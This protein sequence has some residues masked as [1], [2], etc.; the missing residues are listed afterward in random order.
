MNPFDATP[1]SLS[2][3]EGLGFLKKAKKAVKKVV[4]KVDKNLPGA[5][6]I[7]K[8]LERSKKKVVN[9]VKRSPVAQA[10]VLAAGA[11]V[12]GPAVGAIAGKFGMAAGGAK[13][14]AAGVAK[15]AAGAATKTQVAKSTAKL[16]QR[17]VIKQQKAMAAQN[18]ALQEIE[19][20]NAMIATNPEFA[21]VVANMQAQGKSNAEIMAAWA[22]SN[23][24]QQIAIPEVAQTIYPTIFSDLQNQGMSS[25]AAHLVAHDAA[26]EVA[27]EAVQATGNNLQA[28]QFLKYALPIGGLA[29]MFLG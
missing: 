3:Y 9:E 8:E 13:V 27:E 17:P 1:D 19:Q 10:A 4:K 20:I 14:T 25:Q 2:G 23:T 16:A 21:R 7:T 12:L 29:L 26:L 22:Q 6:R 24:Y 28:S 15:A 11:M 5:A 18:K